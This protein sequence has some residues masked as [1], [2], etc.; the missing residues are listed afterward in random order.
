MADEFVK[1]LDA[2]LSEFK[3]LAPRIEQESLR[4]GVFR[5]AQFLRDRVK[6]AAPVSSG[7]PPKGGRFKKFPPGTLRK[8]FKAKRRRGEKGVVAA[9]LT[10]AFYAKFVEFGHTLKG[11]RPNREELGHVPANPF[12]RHAFEAN[13]EQAMEVVRKGVLEQIQKRMER[14]RAKGPKV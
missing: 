11:H 9:G 3:E 12:I 13:Q 2:L 4:T 1:G 8:S 7:E 5:A 14:L 6:E 10:G